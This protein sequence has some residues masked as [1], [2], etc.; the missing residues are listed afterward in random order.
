M[1]IDDYAS[2]LQ[3][4]IKTVTV[5]RHEARG[6]DLIVPGLLLKHLQVYI[7][8]PPYLSWLSD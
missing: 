1:N 2:L 4:H 7:C 6:Q 8:S 5:S 3:L